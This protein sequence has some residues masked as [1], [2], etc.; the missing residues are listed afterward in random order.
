MAAAAAAAFGAATP[1][2][3]G[4]AAVANAAADVALPEPTEAVAAAGPDA[5]F[6]GAAV[7]LLPGAAADALA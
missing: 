6:D 5:T 4:L 2:A 1:G 3:V 7:A